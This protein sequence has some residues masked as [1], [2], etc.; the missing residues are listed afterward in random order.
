MEEL[1]LQFARK[2]SAFNS[3]M[4]GAEEDLTDPVHCNSLEEIKVQTH[5]LFH[6]LTLHILIL[7]F[8]MLSH[9]YSSYSHT[10]IIPYV[11]SARDSLT[12]PELLSSGSF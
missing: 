11:G 9:S 4:E 1:Y 6:T 7:L 3:W 2:A 5:S 8:F 10:A 12:I